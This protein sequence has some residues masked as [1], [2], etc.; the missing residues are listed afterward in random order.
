LDV[1]GFRKGQERQQPME[2][3]R[4]QTGDE[5]LAIDTVVNLKPENERAGQIPSMHHMHDFFARA[6]NC[7]IVALDG[8]SP[9]GFLVA[10]TMPKLSRDASMIY[11]YEIVVAPAY[12]RQGVASK[13]IDLLKSQCRETDVIEIWVGTENDN[14]PAMRLYESTGA[15]CEHANS[16]EFVYQTGQL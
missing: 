6:E 5:Q 15:I 14:I 16:V 11:L 3:K 9:A 13:M 1:A 4:L 12:R 7:L 8:N 2:I 10:Y